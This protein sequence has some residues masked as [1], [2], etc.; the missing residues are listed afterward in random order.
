LFS[1][2]RL[3]ILSV[4]DDRYAG[5][6]FVRK[7]LSSPNAEMEKSLASIRRARTFLTLHGV[8][9]GVSKFANGFL[10]DRANVAHSWLSV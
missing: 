5:F 2:Y 9:Y 1:S 8:L 6:Y 3:R 7:N 4:D 10:G